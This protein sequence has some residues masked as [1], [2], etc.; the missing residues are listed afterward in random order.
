MFIVLHAETSK[1]CLK[2][3]SSD[4]TQELITR[5]EADEA[6]KEKF[7]RFFGLKMRSRNSLARNV[8][9][10]LTLTALTDIEQLFPDT[11]VNVLKD[12]FEALRLYDFFEFLEKVRPRSLRPA[13]SSE[14]VE[15]LRAADD[16]PTKYH[17][18]VA[19]L[20]I[21][22]SFKEVNVVKDYAEKIEAF[23]KNLNSHNEVAMIASPSS[24]ETREI[25][26]EVTQ[27]KRKEEYI[28]V[29]QETIRQQLEIELPR[30]RERLEKEID[31]EEEGKPRVGFT[32][33]GHGQSLSEIKREELELRRELDIRMERGAKLREQ[34]ERE[35]E[36]IKELEKETEKAIS[37]AMD[38]WIYYQGVFFV[39]RHIK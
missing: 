30:E 39:Y 6:A 4:V 35:I 19:V 27:K 16:R 25:L 32:E 13:L 38:K 5:L 1:L 23:F 33:R 26:W 3:L 8:A 9:D 36:K 7:F 24:P 22:H 34:I 14:Q 18:N 15:K 11:P 28:K 17:S 20:V 12:C 31:I 2:D 29:Y 37:T 10:G 21:N